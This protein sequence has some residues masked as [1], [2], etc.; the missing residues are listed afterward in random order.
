MCYADDTAATIKYALVLTNISE[1][2]RQKPL[3]SVSKH[4][5]IDKEII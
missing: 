1:T 4:S 2:H 3:Y 5:A